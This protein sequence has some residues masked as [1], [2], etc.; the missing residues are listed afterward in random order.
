MMTPSVRK[1]ALTA[2]ITSS[3]GWLGAVAGFLALS[4]AGLTSRDAQMVRAAYLAMNVI[5]W[6]VI[7]PLA[8]AAL[9]TGIV[10]SLGTT[11]GLI[12]HYWVLTKLVLTVFAT[13]VLLQ[14]M[15]LIGSVAG[16]AAGMALSAADL[17][18][19]RFALVLHSGGG[20]VVLFVIVTISIFKPWGRTPYGERSR[21]DEREIPT[22]VLP[23]GTQILLVVIGAVL[24]G[25]ATLHLNGHGF[26]GH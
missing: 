5:A 26:H 18:Q 7:V 2:H 9:L 4:I 16:A 11:W 6:F 17:R 20:L 15:K 19:E 13:G 14:K 3:V 25:L 1:A 24:I 23:L 22:E 8:L 21:K 12:R 10:Q